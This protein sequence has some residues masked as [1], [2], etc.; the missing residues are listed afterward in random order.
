M[1]VVTEDFDRARAIL[2]SVSEAKTTDNG[3]SLLDPQADSVRR[4][5]HGA[6]W[7]YLFFP[8]QFYS[9]WLVGKLIFSGQKLTKSA[10][11]KITLAIILDFWAVAW[12]IILIGKLF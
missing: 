12:T 3:N 11:S 2:E 10:K 5:F 9:L 1:Q 4:A 6:F 8:L 7:G